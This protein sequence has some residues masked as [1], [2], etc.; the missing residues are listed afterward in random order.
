MQAKKNAL[1]NLM[2]HD[3]DAQQILHERA[4]RL[5]RLPVKEQSSA[6]VTHYIK[7]RLHT[8]EV[9]GIPFE[10]VKEVIV[11]TPLTPIP[12]T[13][14]YVAGVINRQ[15]FL[16]AI[17]DLRPFFHLPTKPVDN[18]QTSL[19]IIS[20][21]GLTLGIIAEQID[22]SDFFDPGALEAPI[23]LDQA[24]QTKYLLGLHQ[25]VNAILNISELIADF[26]TKVGN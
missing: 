1:I 16:L 21:K 3:A 17:F 5:S 8:S 4:E 22:G 26:Q 23:E 13:P 24:I 25:G 2:P 6:Q 7:F 9:Y 11:N 10:Y 19:I 15:G 18:E 12:R 14:D 20:A